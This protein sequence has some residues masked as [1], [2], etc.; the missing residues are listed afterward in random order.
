MNGLTGAFTEEAL[1]T[2][3]RSRLAA[4]HRSEADTVL[5]D[6]LGLCQG[7]ARVDLAVVNG[8]LHGYE[9]K[10]ERDSLR[11]LGA[12][13]DLYSRVFDRVTLVCSDRH[14]SQALDMVPSWWGVLRI[15][16]ATQNPTF[17]SVRRGRKNPSRDVRALA[18]FLWLEE[19][20]ALLSQRD[21]LR[22]LRGKPR[23]ALWDKICE[24]FGIDEVAEA[25]R[26]HLKATAARRGR[27]AQQS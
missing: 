23:A 20:V 16:S 6:E 26:A 15:V 2:S 25:V 7:S 4:Q 14:V 18:E 11:R 12:Q 5:I 21:A 9:I 17:K 13:S 22:G 10:S 27:F 3:L 1:R 8:Q 24:L 19:A